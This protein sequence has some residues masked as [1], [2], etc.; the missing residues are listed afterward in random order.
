[1]SVAI[2]LSLEHLPL[3]HS[4]FPHFLEFPT[5]TCCLPST[6][7]YIITKGS[8]IVCMCSRTGKLTRKFF[9]PWPPP[10]KLGRT[11]WN[12]AK[13][14]LFQWQFLL[15]YDLPLFLL[16]L[17]DLFIFWLYWYHLSWW[18][19]FSGLNDPS[20]YY[21]SSFQFLLQNLEEWRWDIV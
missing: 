3:S 4:S 11:Y 17:W 19:H 18:I 9:T 21:I 7:W 2:C 8:K 16:G 6:H 1:M 20:F 10:K 12:N 5:T 14:L 13:F 15:K